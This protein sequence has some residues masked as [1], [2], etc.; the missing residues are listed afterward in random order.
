MGYLRLRSGSIWPCVL[1]HAS[2]NTFVQGIY[3]PLTSPVGAAKYITS[4]F[5]AGLALSIVIAAALVLINGRHE[6]GPRRE[7]EM[8]LQATAS[9]PLI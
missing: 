9:Q 4:E 1:L 3:D 2:H 7:Q 5:G 8:S 6:T